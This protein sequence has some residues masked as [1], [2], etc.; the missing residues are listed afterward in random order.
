MSLE[1]ELVFESLDEG[2]SHQEVLDTVEGMRELDVKMNSK[3][4]DTA[5]KQYEVKK[6]FEKRNEYKK[7]SKNKLKDLI[8]KEKKRIK[9]TYPTLLSV[10]IIKQIYFYDMKHKSFSCSNCSK[11]KLEGYYAKIKYVNE[12]EDI[13]VKNV[14]D[15]LLF[16]Y[17]KKCGHV[18]KREA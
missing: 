4:V 15:E 3:I 16:I 8:E 6:K 13:P 1:R 11:Q 14:Q 2:K 10:K 7:A 17:C 9:D 5:L 18:D 12:K